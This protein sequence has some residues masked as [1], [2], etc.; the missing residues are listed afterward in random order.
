METN[1]QDYRRKSEEASGAP[2]DRQ[3]S[4]PRSYFRQK[5]LNRVDDNS[6]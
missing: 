5:S 2:W 4:V 6:M 3:S 1:A